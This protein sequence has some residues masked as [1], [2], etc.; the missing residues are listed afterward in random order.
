MI[1]ANDENYLI[2]LGTTNNSFPR[3]QLSIKENTY[4]GNNTGRNKC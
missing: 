3:Y 4:N 2:S 1:S